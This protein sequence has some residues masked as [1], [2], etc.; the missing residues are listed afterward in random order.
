MASVKALNN[1]SDFNKRQFEAKF[2][3]SDEDQQADELAT[4]GEEGEQTD[5]EEVQADAEEELMDDDKE[6][7]TNV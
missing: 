5:A 3:M 2:E 6:P 1:I 4:P 7:D